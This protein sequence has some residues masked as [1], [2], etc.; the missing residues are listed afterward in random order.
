MEIHSEKDFSKLR[1]HMSDMKRKHSMF[2]HDV[3]RIESA[4][5]NHI[6]TYSKYLVQYRQTKSKRYLENAQVEIDEI[7]RILS[8][9][10]KIELMALLSR[11]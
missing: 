4:I 11:R 1:K 10:E 7:N 6:T 5:E 8:T 3:Q 2:K 9:V